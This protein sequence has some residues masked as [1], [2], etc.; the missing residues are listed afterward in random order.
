MSPKVKLLY[1]EGKSKVSVVK[2]RWNQ[3]KVYVR[4]SIPK[5][6]LFLTGKNHHLK[7]KL[8]TLDPAAKISKMTVSIRC[9]LRNVKHDMVY[10]VL[11]SGQHLNSLFTVILRIL[12]CDLYA[13][14][15]T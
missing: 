1:F 15:S 10:V 6:F 11:E 2:L 3:N 14:K 4:K 8:E 5:I 12:K 7:L 9:Q 13:N